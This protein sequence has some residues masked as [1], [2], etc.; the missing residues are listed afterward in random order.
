MPAY[1]LSPVP[2]NDIYLRSGKIVKPVIIEDAPPSMHKEERSS[3][4]PSDTVPIIEDADLG[5]A[6][7][8]NDESNNT[9]PT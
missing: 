4:H 9:Q 1:S 3:Q 6:K 2:C 7:T 5:M 8:S